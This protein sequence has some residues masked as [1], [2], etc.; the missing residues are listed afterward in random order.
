MVKK[1]KHIGFFII[2]SICLALLLGLSIYLEKVKGTHQLKYND[3][4][5]AYQKIRQREEQ[6]DM[7]KE[8]RVAFY[9]K[10]FFIDLPQS[11][12]YR[13]SDF[14]RSLSILVPKHIFLNRCVI[15][16]KFSTM[17]FKL[18]GFLYGLSGQQ[19]LAKFKNFIQSLQV[20]DN[21]D[22]LDYYQTYES[23]RS[24]LLFIIEGEIE[25]L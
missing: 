5:E 1:R 18:K 16:S 17:E 8:E 11:S 13:A 22:S 23:A 10:I 14:I 19:S 20:L 12:S 21:V 7:V 25:L 15:Q 4:R 2:I 6:I 24:R 9:K 3:E